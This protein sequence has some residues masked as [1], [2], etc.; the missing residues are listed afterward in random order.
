M[1]RKNKAIVNSDLIGSF[2]TIQLPGFSKGTPRKEACRVHYLEQGE[3][4]PLL[5]IHSIGQSIYTWRDLM[6]LL[7]QHYRVIAVDLPGFG[8]SD[9]PAS[10]NYSMDEMASCIFL[11]M[12]VLNLP[13]THIMGVTVGGL[14]V[15]QAVSMR[16]DRFQK[17]IALTPGG[18]T[19]KMPKRIR[20]MEGAGGFFAREAYSEKDLAQDLPL[21]Y[22]DGT[23]CTKEV[24]AQV[25]S[26]CDSFAARQAIM[27]AI[28]NCDEAYTWD[29]VAR[30]R[31]EVL[32]LWGEEDKLSP[33]ER[34]FEVQ[35]YVAKGVYHS[36]RNAG[37]WM[38]EEKS[39]Q[40][41]EVVHRYLAY[42]GEET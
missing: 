41:A 6:P 21:F 2:L 29:C 16:P 7:A 9:R 20:R 11:I 33:L 26:T 14:Y 37:H 35:T 19:A 42:Q 10:L 3:G 17:V 8:H 15:L 36:I 4:E 24:Q 31:H 13:T 30:M 38:H 32:I 12:D 5:L 34:L 27:Y 28:R 39:E 25:F 22:Y 18:I 23:L 40:I 1:E